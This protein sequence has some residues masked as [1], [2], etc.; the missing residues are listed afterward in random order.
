MKGAGV[1][2]LKLHMLHLRVVRRVQFH[3]GVIKITSLLAGPALQH[4]HLAVGSS[5][6]IASHICRGPVASG[7]KI[8]H[9]H[10]GFEMH[11]VRH[12]DER[13][14]RHCR[15]IQGAKGVLG[16]RWRRTISGRHRPHLHVG[17]QF[18]DL[19]KGL[20]I[21]AVHKHQLRPIDSGKHAAFKRSGG[22][23]RCSFKVQLG[24]RLDR[25]EAPILIARG[26]KAQFG[27]AS[28]TGGIALGQGGQQP[29]HGVF[30]IHVGGGNHQAAC[31]S[32]IQ[33]YPR[34][35]SS[36]ASSLGPDFTIRP[37]TNTCT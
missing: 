1:L 23:R 25:R 21:M 7:A 2:I 34:S 3:G 8:I 15:R 26:G 30:G 27:K 35:S 17:R 11:I 22:I 18:A 37:S 14:V 29:I 5:A 31:S 4:G 12:A 10:G 36:R 32:I 9:A 28:A 19:R 20:G 6:N 24:D 13:S 33:S 16:R